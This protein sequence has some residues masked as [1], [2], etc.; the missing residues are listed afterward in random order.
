MS[1]S[2]I[3]TGHPHGQTPPNTR[4]DLEWIHDHEQEL[5]EQFGERMILVFEKKVIG[6]GDTYSE[7]LQNAEQNLPPEVEAVTPVTYFL[8]QR[9]PFSRFR[10]RQV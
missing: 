4:T 3:H 8:R 1:T 7:M 6:V 9:H 5:L 10:I 2:R